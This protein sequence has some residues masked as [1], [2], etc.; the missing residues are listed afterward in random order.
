MTEKF[1]DPYGSELLEDYEQIINDFGLEGFDADL[2]PNP[3]RL[4]RRGL[5]FAGRDMK[6]ISE[7]IRNEKKFYVLSGIMP[8]ADNIHF[9]TKSV[10]DNIK[11]FQE[12]G[13]ETFVLVA[14]LESAAARGVTIEEARKRAMEFHIPCYLALGL[15]INKTIFYFQSQNRD[16][17]K[18]GFEFARKITYNEFKAIY[19]N[20]DPGRIMSA[21]I[22]AGDILYPQLSE[23]M[24]G[25]IP[26]GIDQDPHIRLTRDIVRRSKEKK[27]F[28]PSSMYH[29][30]TP[31]LDGSS[32]MS[33][34]KPDSFIELPE[35]PKTACKKLNRALTGGRETIE[36]QKKLG[37][38]PEKCMVYEMYK[39]H[40]IEDDA[41]LKERYYLCKQ[42]KVMCGECK[43]F[44]CQ[45][46]TQFMEN[47]SKKI[48]ENK[49]K[50]NKVKFIKFSD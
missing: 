8:T 40:L 38:I 43:N 29:K 21:V 13:A 28:L 35:D 22:Q 17:I 34:S 25:I 48:D 24:P 31:A 15:D 4:M 3:N 2:F 27:F 7:A 19:G 37:G 26:T 47:L 14:D 39:Q 10:I 9:G 11:Y 5:V 45:L 42:G 12:Q 20:A 33:K 1:I 23:R 30:Y 46:M 16:V 32:K 41:L 18:M 36:I 6:L 49:K 44:A 50:A